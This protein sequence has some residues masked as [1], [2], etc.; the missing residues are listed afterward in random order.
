LLA[1]HASAAAAL[2][3]FQASNPELAQVN[4]EW[5]QIDRRLSNLLGTI[6]ANRTNYDAVAALPRFTLFPWFFVIPGALLILLAAAVL[7]APGA[8]RTVRW[9]LVV[10]AIGLLLA[11]LAFQMWTRAPKGAAMVSA[12]RT[13]ETR[14][15]VTKVQNDF[16]TITTGE[17]SLSGELVPALEEHGLSTAQIDKALPAVAKL[18]GSWIVILQDLTPLLGVMSNQVADYHAVAALPSFNVFPWVFL[19]AGLLVLA[20]IAL[21]GGRVRLPRLHPRRVAE[22]QIAAQAPTVAQAP[23]VAEPRGPPLVQEPGRLSAELPT[24]GHQPNGHQ[25]VTNHK[26]QD[27]LSPT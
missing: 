14:A 16:A 18:E 9:A 5:P 6:Q 2:K 13:V 20:L 12:F 26:E 17:G 8:W 7:A 22:S 24:N 15:L 10:L 23:A 11:P 27:V 21:R 3:S 19:I 4:R 1:P 25:P